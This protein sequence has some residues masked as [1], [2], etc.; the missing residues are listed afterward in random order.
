MIFVLTFNLEASSTRTALPRG[1]ALMVSVGLYGVTSYSVG[2]RTN[3]IGVRMA[4]GAQRRDVVWLAQKDTLRIVITGAV[5][6]LLLSVP[7]MLL[8]RQGIF[9]LAS[10]DP[11]SVALVVA[12]VVIVSGIASYL[13][14][15]RA[16]GVDPM[17]ALRVE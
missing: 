17:R 2:R 13:P 4:L 10:W 11:L 16:A 6:G 7:L 14:A 8:I 12:L 3:E 15:R 5:I 9:G 1:S